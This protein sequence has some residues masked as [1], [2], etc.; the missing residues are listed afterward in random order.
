LN[1]KRQNSVAVL[2]FFPRMM[3]QFVGIGST[4]GEK[5]DHSLDPPA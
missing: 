3:T 1:G 4:N 5:L 2:K